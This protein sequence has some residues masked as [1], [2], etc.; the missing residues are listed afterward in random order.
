[1]TPDL[2]TRYLGLALKNP[3]IAGA[4]PLSDDLDGVRRLEDGG[5][6]AIV[7]RSLFEE[8]IEG[9]A[10]ATSR[11]MDHST[12][13]Y[14]ES[15]TYLPDP[16]DFVLGPDAYLEH[17]RRCVLH[18]GVPVIASL[19]GTTPGGWLRYAKLIEDAGA[20]AL[21]LNLYRIPDASDGAGA[22]LEEQSVAMVR[23]VAQQ[24][25]IPVAVKLSPYYTS[26]ADV[27]RRLVAAGARGLVLFN[28][29]FEPDID[30]E[31]LEYVSALELSDPRELRARLR[32]IALLSGE[33]PASLAVTGGVHSALDVGKSVLAGADA[34]QLVSVLLRHGTGRAATLLSELASWLEEHEYPSLASLRG[35]LDA[36]HCPNPAV[37]GRANYARL[38]QTW[39][40]LR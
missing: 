20:A 21:E 22:A 23:D 9:E 32:W 7:L 14:G 13:S 34:V 24:V 33:V 25:A 11:A 8:Q 4:S 12:E 3:L 19:N 15:L 6:A 1:V 28:R 5:V 2:R 26:L 30:V 17:L 39:S 37:L 31:A 18:V 29:Y 27:S 36:R 40:P 38:L 35:T 16:D 10:L